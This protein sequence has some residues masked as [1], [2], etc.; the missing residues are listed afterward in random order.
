MN[1]RIQVYVGELF[2]DA[3]KSKLIDE[4]R[5]ELTADLSDKYQDLLSRGKSADEAFD[6]AVSNIGDIDELIRDLSEAGDINISSL[7]IKLTTQDFNYIKEDDSFVENFKE[8][9]SKGTHKVR[10]IGAASWLL[11][12]VVL[13]AYFAVNFLFGAWATSW[14]IFVIGAVFQLAVI[15]VLSEKSKKLLGTFLIYT[16]AAVI[17]LAVSFYL[18]NQW[19]KTWLIFLAAVAVQQGLRFFR[20]YKESK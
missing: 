15:S 16:V 3:P 17:Y 1:D 13:I 18:K 14:I 11:W 7:K 12:A 19:D 5:E 6:A 10:L 8:K 2:R 20:I 4:V 9:I